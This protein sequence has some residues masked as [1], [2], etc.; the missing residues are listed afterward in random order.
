MHQA[1]RSYNLSECRSLPKLFTEE[2]RRDQNY[3]EPSSYDKR[4]SVC[5]YSKVWVTYKGADWYCTIGGFEANAYG[6]CD[7]FVLERQFEE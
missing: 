3:K 6:I 5:Y 2:N 4:C 7:E 1:M